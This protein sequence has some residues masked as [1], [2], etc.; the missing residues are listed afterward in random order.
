MKLSDKK[1]YWRIGEPPPPLDKHSETKHAIIEEYVRRYIL[2]MMSRATI[3]LL[4]LSLVDGFCGGGNYTKE[5]GSLADGSPIRLLQA[6]QQARAELNVGRRLPRE[7]SVDYHFNDL[8][9]DTTDYL[10]Y[11]LNGKFEEG[12]LDTADRQRFEITTG[13]FL[14]ELP[15][16]LQKIKS[17]RMGEHA[18]FVLDQY[19]YDDIPLPQIANIL[20]YLEGAEVILTFN[21]GSLITYLSDRAAN[22]KPLARIGLD[23]YIPWERIRHLKATEKQ[24]WRRIIQ[25][26]IAQGIRT[27]SG[28]NFMTLFFVKPHGINTWDY[29]LIHLSNRYRAHDVMKTLHWEHATEFGHELEPG[30]FV[31]GYDANQDSDY[32]GQSTLVFGESSKDSCIDG[33][34][35][36]FG[37]RI[38]SENGP[39]LIADLL[40]GCVSNSMGAESHLM[41]SM[42]QLHSSKNIVISTKDGRIRR[43][44]KHYSN[45]DIVEAN[46]QIILIQ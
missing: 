8:L 14:A 31:L 29:W 40:R 9:P 33:V 36:Y 44:S 4:Q 23:H 45:D 2:T 19:D 46:R 30:V 24:H 34:R 39:V 17:R 42:R 12:C 21:I 3:P 35:E 25:R 22:R 5:S 20:R 41:A 27:E 26:H 10:R 28:A 32:T 38:F 43:P 37:E 18:I 7:V 16:M 13:D 1:Y 6:V 11:W 15:L